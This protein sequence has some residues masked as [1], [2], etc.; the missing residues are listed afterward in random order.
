[1]GRCLIPCFSNSL[2]KIKFQCVISEVQL[3][4][5]EDNKKVNDVRKGI[6]HFEKTK[7]FVL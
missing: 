2:R 1:M 5:N 6:N 7:G 3:Q 4:Y